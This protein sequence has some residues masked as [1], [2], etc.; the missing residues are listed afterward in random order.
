[1]KFKT[2]ETLLTNCKELYDEAIQKDKDLEKAFGG[3]SQ[4]MTD[5]WSNY[6]EN[7]INILEKEYNDKTESINW[8]FWESMCNSDGYMDFENDGV[9]YEGSPKNIWLE[10]NGMLDERFSKDNYKTYKGM[11]VNPK[12]GSLYTKNG[13]NITQYIYDDVL[14]RHNYDLNNLKP[15]EEKIFHYNDCYYVLKSSKDTFILEQKSYNI[16]DEVDEVNEPNKKDIKQELNEIDMTH[17]VKEDEDMIYA[18]KL[19]LLKDKQIQLE[20][21][22]L[23][24]RLEQ[25][26]SDDIANEKVTKEDFAKK[27]ELNF[28]EL[29]LLSKNKENINRINQNLNMVLMRFI[30]EPITQEIMD[31]IEFEIKNVLVNNV[32]LGII[33]EYTITSITQ[34]A[35]VKGTILWKGASS[36]MKFK[37]L[38]LNKIEVIF[39]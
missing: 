13:F 23:A 1:M 9:T 24:K 30:G 34:D 20:S 6:I 5:W 35:E 2:F 21:I 31:M 27:L 10:L 14:K 17:I 32:N 4:I 38:L 22:E 12:N 16:V 26:V 36:P 11:R 18:H 7:T 8:L 39:T 29:L 28:E 37:I 19:I 3:D 33:E 15:F 25:S